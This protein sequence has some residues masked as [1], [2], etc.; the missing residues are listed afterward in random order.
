MKPRAFFFG[1][2]F[3]SFCLMLVSALLLFSSIDYL[4]FPFTNTLPNWLQFT[5][6]YG[7]QTLILFCL[8]YFW[9]IRRFPVER[10]Q[11]FFHSPGLIKTIGYVLFIFVSYFAFALSFSFIKSQFGV[12]LPG[13]AEQE[14]LLAP[15]GDGIGLLVAFIVA[16]IVAPIIE[17]YI[18]RGWGLICLPTDTY[19]TLAILLN[20]LLFA[21]MHFQP[22]SILPLIFLGSMLALVR[23]RSNSLLPGIVFHVINNSLAFLADYYLK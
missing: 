4:L 6:G 18:F 19:P 3:F 1:K 10:Q 20:G 12:A 16:V 13:F 8:V 23:L 11:I 5:I 9:F 22:Q 21:I 2:N 15:L 17:E 14:S 7:L